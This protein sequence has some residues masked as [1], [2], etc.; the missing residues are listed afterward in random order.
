[1]HDCPKFI[2]SNKKDESIC[3]QRVKK[4]INTFPPNKQTV[5]IS[6]GLKGGGGLVFTI[7]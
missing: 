1:M 7:H 6:E 2:V 5:P 4:E 3:I